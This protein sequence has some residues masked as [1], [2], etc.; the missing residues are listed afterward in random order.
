MTV[1]VEVVAAPSEKLSV[2][3]PHASVAVAVPKAAVISLAAG[4]H[5][6]VVVVPVVE[7]EGGV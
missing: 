1:Q 4:L 5:P 2:T 6:S 7:I 3:G